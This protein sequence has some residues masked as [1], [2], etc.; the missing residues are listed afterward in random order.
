MCAS[1]AAHWRVA[2]DCG[3]KNTQRV[4]MLASVR[5]LAQALKLV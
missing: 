5:G 4:G 3:G 2:S 1:W